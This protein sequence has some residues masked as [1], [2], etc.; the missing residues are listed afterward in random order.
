MKE[1]NICYMQVTDTGKW[2]WFLADEYGRPFV[3]DQQE[4]D[5]LEAVTLASAN[6]YGEYRSKLTLNG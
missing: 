3:Q 4:Y 1:P 5:S 6:D 2:K